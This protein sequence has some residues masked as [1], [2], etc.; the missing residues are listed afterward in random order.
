MGR[1]GVKKKKLGR[2]GRRAKNEGRKVE[3]REERERVSS[4][5]WPKATL[6]L[7]RSALGVDA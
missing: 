3:G 2:E 4:V 7:K 5:G 1:K 6:E